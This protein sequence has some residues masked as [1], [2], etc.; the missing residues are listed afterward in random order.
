ML[1][2]ISELFR[3]DEFINSSAVFPDIDKD[4]LSKELK[5]AVIGGERG[6]KNHPEPQATSMDH[7]ELQVVSRVEEL[8]RR[9]LENFETNRRVY[10]ERLNLA[11]SARMQVET[12]ANDAKAKFREDVTKWK[13]MMVTPRERVQ[14]TFKY[15]EEFKKANRLTRPAKPAAGWLGLIALAL[16]MIVIESIANSYLFA[17]AN[18]LGLLGGV[19]A[20]FLVSLGNVC[21]SI[22]LGMASRFINV[23]MFVNPIKK[24]AGLVFFVIWLGFAIG[25]NLSVAHFRD[26]V[27]LIG[28]WQAAGQAALDSL[29]ASPLQ[30]GTMESYILLIVGAFISIIS[31][32]KGYRSFDPY[33]SYSQVS[34]DV[35]DA[36][37]DYI[38]H[39]IDSINELAERREDAVDA[40]R[41]ANDEVHRNINDS[42][43]A[44]FGQKA[45][46]SNLAPFLDQC[47]VA[48]QYLLAVYRDANKAMRR[49]PTPDY[50]SKLYTFEKFKVGA[51]D[52]ARRKSAEA[53]VEEV[54]D[55][56]SSSISEIFGVFD[57]AV[58]G[59]YE[60]DELE[61]TFIERSQKHRPD[62]ASSS[63]GAEY[64]SPES[65]D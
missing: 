2:K 30:L 62:T 7:V 11:V 55:L 52:S 49:E 42:V 57:A 13:G 61:G 19:M 39:L 10:S 8:R 44:L 27:E 25:Y 16:G 32:L 1:R 28:D 14:D 26:S 34:Q 43:D 37:D 58:S 24:A 63:S 15:R 33:P 54:A 38:A 31:F 21:V 12:E 64:T 47:D 5:L 3:S 17:E 60:I 6:A 35:V 41:A 50:F 20:A 9:G 65:N 4:R 53:Q 48:A 45:L 18:S 29:A 59:H 51:V 56:V 40:L 23:R 36:R 46:Q 22:L